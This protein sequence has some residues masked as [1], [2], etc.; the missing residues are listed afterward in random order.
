L[1]IGVTSAHKVI[2]NNKMM[3][4]TYV[5]I[6]YYIKEVVMKRWIKH[7]VIAAIMVIASVAV[8]GTSDGRSKKM[9]EFRVYKFSTIRTWKNRL[10]S[11]LC[12]II[13]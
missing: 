10:N 2:A 8:I 1:G 11:F 3:C 5:I 4:Y 7:F 13:N 12:Y 9:G 6:L